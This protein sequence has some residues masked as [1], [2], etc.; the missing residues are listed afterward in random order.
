LKGVYPYVRPWPHRSLQQ[1]DCTAHR[2]TRPDPRFQRD[3]CQECPDGCLELQYRGVEPLGVLPGQD[4]SHDDGPNS[5]G[6]RRDGKQAGAAA[7][8]EA[9][10]ERIESW[11]KIAARYDS[12]PETQEGRKEL[13]ARAKIAEANRA[14]AMAAYHHYEMASAAL[15][16][17]IVLASA[18]I[19]TGVAALAW[20]SGG[21]GI[22]GLAFSFIGFFAPMAVHLI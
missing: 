22:V 15:Q 9:L 7:K 18:E 5:D 12:E 16:I 19:I 1:E 14:Q 17:A 2:G 6:S 20:I 21:L 13:S 3:A 8:K 10:Q 4:D 11:K